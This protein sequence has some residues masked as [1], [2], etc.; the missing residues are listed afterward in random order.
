MRGLRILSG[1]SFALWAN[2]RGQLGAV[3]AILRKASKRLGP[4]GW[5]AGSIPER[6][7]DGWRTRVMLDTGLGRAKKRLPTL[8]APPRP[9]LKRKVSIRCARLA[10]RPKR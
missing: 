7:P 5:R 3:R 8:R 9:R 2:S 6:L 4:V 10:P 1:K